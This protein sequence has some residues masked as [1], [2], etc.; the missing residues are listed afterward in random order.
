M[1]LIYHAAH[2]ISKTEKMKLYGI[3]ENPL[4][5]ISKLFMDVLEMA[6]QTNS[7]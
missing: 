2:P 5:R 3:S 7:L 1:P 4:S 6:V